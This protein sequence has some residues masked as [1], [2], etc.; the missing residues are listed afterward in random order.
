MTGDKMTRAK[1]TR[2]KIAVCTMTIDE[3]MT[4]DK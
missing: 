4:V 2:D 1:M 3:K